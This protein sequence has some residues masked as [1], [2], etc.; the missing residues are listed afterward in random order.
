VPIERK[1][2]SFGQMTPGQRELASKLIRASLSAK[3]FEKTETIRRLENVLLDIEKGRGPTRDPDRYFVTLFGE[4][5]SRCP[6]GWRY[7]GHHVSLNWTVLD[8]K[9]I[10]S[11]P[12]FLGANPAEVRFGS[13]RGTRALGAEED[14]ARSLLSSLNETQRR[15][16]L[17]SAPAPADII[18]SSQRQTSILE[19]TGIAYDHLDHAQQG[20]LLMLI[21]EHA[22]AQV[23]VE[24]GKRLA[25]IRKEGVARIK[26]AWM[27]G[28][29]PG[30]GHYY[31]VQGP[32][33][34]IEFD[35]TQDHANHIHSVWRDFKGDFGA[36]LLEMHYQAYH[37]DPQRGSAQ[38]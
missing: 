35:N 23:D 15:E 8:G 20:I 32:T 38:P 30:Q 22:G 21:R 16:A 29:I 18:T 31:R 9:L 3:G 10:A 33:F 5:A 24:A 25:A 6:W 2:I 37:T 34:L 4:P 36:D 26:F 13:M 14:L 27:G 28:T 11:S 1:G 12:Q 19:D 17:L 7:E